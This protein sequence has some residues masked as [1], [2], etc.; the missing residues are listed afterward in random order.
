MRHIGLCALTICALLS[1]CTE[2]QA[3]DAGDRAANA[4]ATGVR[5]AQ[6]A[7]RKTKR[8]ADDVALAA[9]VQANLVAQTGVNGFHVRVVARGTTVTLTGRAAT[10]GLKATLLAAAR[11]TAGVA[12]VVDR[13]EI[14][15]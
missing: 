13:V 2:R 8:V 12:T 7:L 14:R 9:A 5:A 10:P 15:S 3:N 4:V 1:A 11:K 6:P